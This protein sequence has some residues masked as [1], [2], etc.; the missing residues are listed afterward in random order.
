M[1]QIA[2]EIHDA[3]PRDP[4][5]PPGDPCSYSEV[6]DTVRLPEQ[7]LGECLPRPLDSTCQYLLGDCRLAVQ[8]QSYS[9][10]YLGAITTF[11]GSCGTGLVCHKETF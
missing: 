2:T 1:V 6:L 8:S 10:A 9:Q 11:V 3:A 4:L 7:F 5:A